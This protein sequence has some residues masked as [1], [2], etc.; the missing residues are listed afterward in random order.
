VRLTNNLPPNMIVPFFFM[1]HI[2]TVSGISFFLLYSFVRE[3]DR[4][5]RM[6]D[7]E[8]E[9]SEQLLLNVLPKEVAPRLK[10]GG[11]TIAEHFDSAS[12]LFADI[13]GSTTLFADMQPG[14]IVDW[15]HQ[16]FSTFDALLDEHGLEKIR[17]IGDSYMVAAGVPTPRSDHARA[18]ARM[19][20]EM[21]AQLERMPARDGRRMAF[22]MG[23]NSGPMVGGVIGT[24][25]FHY[26]L[27]G[28]TVNTASRMESHG[29]A[30]RIQVTR[31]SY[32]L[33]KEEFVLEARGVIPI[34]G[35]G[36]MP[37]WYL[38]GRR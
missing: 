20:L 18:L 38:V 31:A 16:L 36:E 29:E 37:T 1:L 35:K 21:C 30:G 9:R 4:A 14:E 2:G 22:R 32:E 11:Q 13:V 3:K 10:Q 24:S 34:K 15:L 33:L 23:M 28:D 6:L 12:V 5:Y 27:W 19:A 8:R 7:L 26:D 17:T 25:K